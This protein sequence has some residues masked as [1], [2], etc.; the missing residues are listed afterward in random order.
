MAQKRLS[1]SRR[2][3]PT[4]T[5]GSWGPERHAALA[6][7]ATALA[8]SVGVMQ[9]QRAFWGTGHGPREPLTGGLGRRTAGDGDGE[10]EA[11]QPFS[12]PATGVAARRRRRYFA[13]FCKG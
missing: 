7:S 3:P 1:R 11:T 8:R 10:G 13:L 2:P 12:L 4:R 9:G 5:G 6:G